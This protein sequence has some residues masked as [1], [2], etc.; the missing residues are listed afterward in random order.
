[1]R[2]GG[3]APRHGRW[4]HT[5]AALLWRAAP[6]I[7]CSAPSSGTPG[8]HL[9]SMPQALDA[10]RGMFYLHS[11]RCIHRDLKTPNL[12]R[13]HAC[14][15]LRGARPTS[16]H[17]AGCPAC[18]PMLRSWHCAPGL[19]LLTRPHQAATP[20]PPTY[21]AL[22]PPCPFRQLVD[23]NWR[24][25]V[26]GTPSLHQLAA[27]GMRAA[28]P[29]PAFQAAAKITREEWYPAVGKRQQLNP[30]LQHNSPRY[31]PAQTSISAGCWRM[32]PAS[33][34]VRL[35]PTRAGLLPRCWR[36]DVPRRRQVRP[37]RSLA[38]T[39]LA[40]APGEP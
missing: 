25:K 12:V 34:A 33:A 6:A 5:V 17:P 26:A 10:S 19:P 40:P 9:P 14:C 4:H 7:A 2:G 22:H 11:R 32:P 38:L 36:G 18:M 3:Q 28:S 23:E 24:C 29:L 15:A 37:S 8:P 13:A 16:Q 30:L 31:C 35:S 27:A 1:M 20:P 39:A 21:P